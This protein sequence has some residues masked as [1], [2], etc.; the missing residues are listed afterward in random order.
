MSDSLPILRQMPV[1]TWPSVLQIRAGVQSQV[2]VDLLKSFYCQEN[3]NAPKPKCKTRR[4]PPNVAGAG[5]G[6]G[7]VVAGA[8]AVVGGAGAGAVGA[9]AGAGAG[10]I[11]NGA[12]DTSAQQ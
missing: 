1:T 9:G 4:Q 2:A 7:A 10:Y 3:P 5:A 12:T 6:A 11:D 8:G